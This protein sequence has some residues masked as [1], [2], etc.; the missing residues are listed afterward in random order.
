MLKKV[1][2]VLILIFV[3]AGCSTLTGSKQINFDYEGILVKFDDHRLLVTTV[4]EVHNQPSAIWIITSTKANIG[5]KVG[6]NYDGTL[7]TSNP[8]QG[9][10]RGVVI[11]EQDPI[12]QEALKKALMAVSS[13][14]EFPVVKEISSDKQ[15]QVWNVT[16][17]ELKT[18]SIK[19]VKIDLTNEKVEIN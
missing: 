4:D 8:G 3:T 1:L 7:E 12:L 17:M 19:K 11:L 9:K 6:V 14:V 15:K 18:K 16:C 13:Q 2:C 5:T 10:A